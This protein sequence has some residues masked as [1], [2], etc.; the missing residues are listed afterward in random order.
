VGSVTH[1][2]AQSVSCS[3]FFV[4]L[5]VSDSKERGDEGRSRLWEKGER[6]VG[7]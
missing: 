5:G 4:R 7:K 2:G 6:G 3:W 1:H